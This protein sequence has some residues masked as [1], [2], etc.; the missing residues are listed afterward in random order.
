M[1]AEFET[2]GGAANGLNWFVSGHRLHENG[3]RSDSPSDVGQLFGKFA[4]T[5]GDG[6]VCAGSLVQPL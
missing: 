4:E 2:G 5:T 3:W 1:A 6:N